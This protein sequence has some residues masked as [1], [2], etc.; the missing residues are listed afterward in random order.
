MSGDSCLL[1]KICI[2][3]LKSQKE[4]ENNASHLKNKAYL[5]VARTSSRELI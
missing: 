3:T 2:S 4:E 1:I 5:L